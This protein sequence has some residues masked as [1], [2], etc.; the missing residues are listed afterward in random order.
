VASDTGL[1][2][3]S[4]G[5]RRSHDSPVPQVVGRRR[6]P[7]PQSVRIQSRLRLRSAMRPT[8]RTRS[9]LAHCSGQRRAGAPAQQRRGAMRLPTSRAR[10]RRGVVPSARPRSRLGGSRA[11]RQQ[12]QSRQTRQTV[13]DPA[14]WEQC[15]RSPASQGRDAPQPPQVHRR[16]PR[17]PRPGARSVSRDRAGPARGPA[18]A[19]PAT[20]AP[21]EKAGPARSQRQDRNPGRRAGPESQGGVQGFRGRGGRGRAEERR[22]RTACAPRAKRSA[23]W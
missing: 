16:N 1:V 4:E 15:G 8:A 17:K 14:G 21:T 12:S 2:L 7:E 22:P 5:G 9:W 6:G 18:R 11:A 23:A 19:R 13:S 10:R 20:G 3:D